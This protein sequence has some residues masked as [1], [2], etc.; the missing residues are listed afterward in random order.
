[1]LADL[2]L[3]QVFVIDALVVGTISA[4][5]AV[6]LQRRFILFSVLMFASALGGT[7]L[8]RFSQEFLIA[9]FIISAGIL[10]IVERSQSWSHYRRDGTENESVEDGASTLGPHR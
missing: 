5:T 6:F 10:I 2:P 8:P 7:L 3:P 9:A 1:M 4:T